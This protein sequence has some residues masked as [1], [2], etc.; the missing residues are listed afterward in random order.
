VGETLARS[1]RISNRKL[2]DATKW[3]PRHASVREGWPIVARSL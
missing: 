1:Q 3:S 2:K